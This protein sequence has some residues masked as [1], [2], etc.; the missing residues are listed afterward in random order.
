MWVICLESLITYTSLSVDNSTH[1]LRC[2]PFYSTHSRCLYLF[3][4]SGTTRSPHC[5]CSVITRFSPPSGRFCLSSKS[6]SMDATKILVLNASGRHG[7]SRGT[8]IIFYH[9]LKTLKFRFLTRKR[10]SLPLQFILILFFP[11]TAFGLY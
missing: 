6:S 9:S 11:G 1:K 8:P 4:K 7:S 3:R 10:T 2:Y 5:A